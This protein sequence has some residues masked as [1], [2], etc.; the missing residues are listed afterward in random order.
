MQLKVSL[1][2]DLSAAT[3]LADLRTGQYKSVMITAVNLQKAYLLNCFI[4]RCN[5]QGVRVLI[6]SARIIER[7]KTY[8]TLYGKIDVMPSILNGFS[9]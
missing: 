2:N 6:Q 9:A 3:A 8:D 7:I 1:I 4:K 5:N